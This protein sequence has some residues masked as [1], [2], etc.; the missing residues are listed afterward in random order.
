MEMETRKFDAQL[1]RKEGEDTVFVISTESLDRHGTVL[2]GWDL[3]QFKRNPIMA[4]QHKT[5]STDPDDI[6]GHW[7]IWEEEGRLMGKPVFEPEEINPKAAKI[8]RK[9]EHGTLRG[10]SVGFIPK[11]HRWGQK[12][13]G[14]D[15]DVLY[16]ERN[17]LLEVSIVAVPSNPDAL[18][19]SADELK[20]EFKE[21][22]D[23]SV[24]DAVRLRFS[25]NQKK[26]SK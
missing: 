24:R 14:E 23:E 13:K 19:R 5:G 26:Y 2:R 8:Q 12:S 22:K 15:E 11:E 17:E 10:V 18:K 20:Q 4:Y 1:T 3:D 6:L 25:I 9:I 16:L 7:E 21:V